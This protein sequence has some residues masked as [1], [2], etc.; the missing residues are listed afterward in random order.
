MNPL[1][2]YDVYENTNKESEQISEEYNLRRRLYLV[3]AAN[4]QAK[5]LIEYSEN[6]NEYRQLPIIRTSPPIIP[7]TC[8]RFSDE[9]WE[10]EVNNSKNEIKKLK[11]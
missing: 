3:S 6:V 5:K 4:I 9:E 10:Y 8:D 7:G 1:F 2:L 11:N